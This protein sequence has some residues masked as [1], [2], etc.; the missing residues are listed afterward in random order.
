MRPKAALL[1]QT[2]LLPVKSNVSFVLSPLSAR[3]DHMQLSNLS[4]VYVYRGR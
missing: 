2:I 1:F 3:D 4:A